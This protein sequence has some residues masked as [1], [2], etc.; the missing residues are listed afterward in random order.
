MQEVFEFRPHILISNLYDASEN[1]VFEDVF[2]LKPFELQLIVLHSE[3]VVKWVLLASLKDVVLIFHHLCVE[4]WVILLY[5]FHCLV[6]ERP[7]CA[8]T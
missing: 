1:D 7:E 3:N 4:N 5:L 8:M 6:V 2:A